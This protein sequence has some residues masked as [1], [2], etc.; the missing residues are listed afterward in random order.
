MFLLANIKSLVSCVAVLVLNLGCA[1]YTSETTKVRSHFYSGSYGAALKELDD[2]SIKDQDRNRLLFLLERAMILDRQGKRKESRKAL[3]EAD[4]LV[5]QLF[6]ANYAKEGAA[7]LYN[8]SA[9]DY[10]GEDYE[11]VAIHTMLALSFLE[12][13]ELQ[14]ARVEAKAINSRLEDINSFYK[15]NKNK[16]NEDAFARYLSGMIYEAKGEIDDA[17]IDYRA[18]LALYEGSYAKHFDTSTPPQLVEA[19]YRLAKVRNRQ[20]IVKQLEKAYPQYARAAKASDEGL[21]NVVVIHQLGMIAVK[22]Q[23]DFVLMWDGKP[24]RMSFPTIPVRNKGW[25]GRT[26]VEFKDHKFEKS[27]IFQNMDAIAHAT[28]EDKRLRVTA[29]MAARLVLKDQIAQQARKSFGIVGELGASIYGAVTETADTRGWTL[30]PSLISVTRLRLP[31][32]EHTLRIISNG[33]TSDI[34]KVKLE[35]NGFYFFSGVG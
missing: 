28:L 3:M 32:G 5:E 29:K 8:D 21:A 20:N 14:A 15:E 9:T 1:T 25:L 24:M 18:A 7:L 26:G 27:E 23:F 33:K 34:V 16:Y 35:K 6:K 12:D 31:P 2:S 10:A 30:F 11:K 4:K 13:K 17:I 22:R 19:L